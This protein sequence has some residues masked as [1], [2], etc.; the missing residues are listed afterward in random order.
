MTTL[1]LKL[2]QLIQAIDFVLEQDDEQDAANDGLNVKLTFKELPDGVYVWKAD[3]P[4]AG[5]SLLSDE[6]PERLTAVN[7]Q[8]LGDVDTID[9]QQLY[10]DF[11]NDDVELT[12]PDYAHLYFDPRS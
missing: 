12:S 4:K 7:I 6:T 3:D 1:T 10:F 5:S 2:H 9:E 11:T 8:Q